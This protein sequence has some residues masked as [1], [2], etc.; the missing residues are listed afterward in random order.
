[1]KIV[2]A[3][4]FLL[5]LVLAGPAASAPVLNPDQEAQDAVAYLVARGWLEGYPGGAFKGDRA[6]T[7]YELTELL[8]R[9]QPPRPD[10]ASAADLQDLQSLTDGLRKE[11]DALGGRV[12]AQ[13]NTVDL[14]EQRLDH[15][16]RP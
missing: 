9:I 1:M 6:I 7:R 4:M 15:L 2:V 14:T 5:V 11:L 10:P 12:Q 8:D 16:D 3:W 13:E